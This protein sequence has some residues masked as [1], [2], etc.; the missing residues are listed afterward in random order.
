L[1][2]ESRIR[3]CPLKD[4]SIEREKQMDNSVL[5]IKPVTMGP[6]ISPEVKDKQEPRTNK[7]VKAGGG[8]H[9]SPGSESEAE[10]GASFLPLTREQT[11]AMVDNV[12]RLL[13]VLNTNLSFEI[14]EKAGQMVVKVVERDT[15]QI[16]REIPPEDMLRLQEK[17]QESRGVLFDVKA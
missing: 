8:L 1:L 16:I 3:S 11:Q 4:C 13:K 9:R 17:L 15:K 6:W 2:A 7:P 5:E 12:E 10:L 14:H